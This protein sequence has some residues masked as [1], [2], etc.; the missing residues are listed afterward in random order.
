MEKILVSSKIRFLANIP[1]MVGLNFVT[2]ISILH[3]H[4]ASFLSNKL[5]L[6]PKGMIRMILNSIMAK[7]MLL[8]TF[9]LFSFH[10]Y[11]SK[12]ALNHRGKVRPIMHRIFNNIKTIY[13]LSLQSQ[14]FQDPKNFR[15]ISHSFEKASEAASQISQHGPKDIA[16]R[17][18][19]ESLEKDIWK[20]GQFFRDKNFSESRFI[21]KNLVSNC[22]ACH[23]R[24]KNKNSFPEAMVPPHLEKAIT[25]YELARLKTATRQF[26]E[27][28]NLFKSIL[29]DKEYSYDELAGEGVITDFFR[30]IIRVRQDPDQ[31]IEI[32]RILESR[33]DLDKT[34]REIIKKWVT[35]LEYLKK[36]NY[37]KSPPSLIKARE[38]LSRIRVVDSEGDLPI[39]SLVL[40]MSASAILH[41]L[42]GDSSIPAISRAESYYLLGTTENMLGSSFWLNESQYYWEAAIRVL[43]HSEV[44]RKA[45]RSI[46]ENV[47]LGYTGSSGTRMPEEVDTWLNALE[48]LASLPGSSLKKSPV[49]RGS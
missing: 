1:G 19:G 27:A 8:C 22:L 4:S 49:N 3:T 36:T 16:F 35:D 39:H 12:G 26:K 23:T 44:S 24:F 6:N 38:V 20:A 10:A 46:E 21:V 7:I 13:T 47:T 18:T 9:F 25:P 29:A 28:E 43:P 5:D 14:K 11:G 37:F 40:L 2:K 30:L 32:C 15:K 17:L 42:S 41:T 48:K 45:F 31:A 34:A 33:K